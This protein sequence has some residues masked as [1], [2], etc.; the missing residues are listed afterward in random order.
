MEYRTLNDIGAT[1]FC[2][3]DNDLVKTHNLHLYMVKI[4]RVLEVID[5]REIDKETIEQLLAYPTGLTIFR[6]EI[7]AFVTKFCF[8]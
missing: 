4:S 5:R 6:E 7:S 1:G 8:V 2:F 3:F